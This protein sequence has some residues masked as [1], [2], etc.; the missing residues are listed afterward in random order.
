M[1]ILSRG[2][3]FNTHGFCLSTSL[4]YAAENQFKTPFKEISSSESLGLWQQVDVV[5]MDPR[6]DMTVIAYT[7]SLFKD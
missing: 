7:N 6:V 2:V 4:S 5:A 3:I 1:T